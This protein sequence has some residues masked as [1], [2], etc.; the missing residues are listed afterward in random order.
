MKLFGVY[1]GGKAEGCHIEA[2]D[3]VFAI[4]NTIEDTYDYL[5]KAW[6]GLPKGLH[7]D[8]WVELSALDGFKIKVQKEMV[9]S[10]SEYQVY[11]LN[12]GGYLK[13]KF[14]EQHEDMFV[15]A[16]SKA[17]ARTQA[18]KRLAQR[19]DLLHV[20]FSYDVDACIEAAGF[21]GVSI[22]VT[23]SSG[24]VQSELVFNNGYFK[25]S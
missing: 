8:S 7:M 14:G 17:D 21:E 13:P 20:D 11:F 24:G 3:F 2:H 19:F 12:M 10:Q 5:K 15:V 4:G 23:E 9:A 18:R 22:D 6:F 25:I 1:L 16:K